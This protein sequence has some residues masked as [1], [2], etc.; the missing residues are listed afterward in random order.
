MLAA[1]KIIHSKLLIRDANKRIAS[2]D[3]QCG[4]VYTGLLPD[5]INIVNRAKEEAVDYNKFY[6]QK[7]PGKV[8]AS[9]DI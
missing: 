2:V 9:L 1:E 6:C 4:L 7:I 3:R 8:M 5:G